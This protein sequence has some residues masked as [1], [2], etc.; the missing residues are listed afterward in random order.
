[1]WTIQRRSMRVEGPVLQLLLGLQ[2]LYW[3]R[4]VLGGMPSAELKMEWRR[5]FCEQCLIC[6][7][8]SVTM[9]IL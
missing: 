1:M 7:S 9:S 2:E 4:R 8:E 6:L 3:D 5:T